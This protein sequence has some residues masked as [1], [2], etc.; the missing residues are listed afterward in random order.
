MMFSVQGPLITT[1]TTTIMTLP[2]VPPE[3]VVVQPSSQY[4]GHGLFVTRKY[5][6]HEKI[7]NTTCELMPEDQ[8]SRM[9]MIMMM[10][11]VMMMIAIIS[12]G[13]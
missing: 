9:M 4:G 13:G 8:G 5:Q 7:Y 11:V 3:G 1:T 2:L 10:M 6:P 12:K